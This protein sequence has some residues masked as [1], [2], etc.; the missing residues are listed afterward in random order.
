MHWSALIKG[1]FLY[2][3]NM[4]KKPKHILVIRNSAMGDVAMCV[5]VLVA[6]NK[7]Y[8]QIKITVLTRENFAPFF[9]NIPNTSVKIIQPETTHKGFWGLNKLFWQLRRLKITEVADLHNVL[10]SNILKGFFKVS[11]T[12]FEQIDKGREEKKLLT[13]WNNDKVLEPLVSTHERYVK[14]FKSLGYSFSLSA[15]D[16]LPKE[17]LDEITRELAG[18]GIQK[19]IGIA[20]FA[21]HEAKEYPFKLMLQVIEELHKKNYKIFLFGGGKKE[22]N[23]LLNTA[24]KFENVVNAAG[25][26]NMEKQLTLISNL[27]AMI[28]MDSGNGHLAAMYG[29]P[30]ITVWGVTHPYTGFAPFNQSDDNN[31]LPDL[32]EYDKIP[33]SIYGNKVPPGYEKVMYSILPERIIERVVS[34]VG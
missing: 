28:S 33:T 19:W 17:K 32:I 4:F 8:P 18:T 20:P 7:A 13:S 34:V 16:I 22:A 14:V 24:Q 30:V 1:A 23:L 3:H 12:P 6:F 10:R 31:I 29:I 5:P 21:Q 15:E 11:G 2:L 27:D 9:K 25:I 26:L